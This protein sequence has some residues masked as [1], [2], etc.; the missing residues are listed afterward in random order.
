[1][2]KGADTGVE[3]RLPPPPPGKRPLDKGMMK[4]G[5]GALLFVVIT[6]TVLFAPFL[7]HEVERY[8]LG[9]IRV[10]N[11]GLSTLCEVEIIDEGVG[12][13]YSATFHVENGTGTA[14]TFIGRNEMGLL[15]ASVPGVGSF[16]CHVE[17]D[18]PTA[19]EKTSLARMLYD[20]LMGA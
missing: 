16:F 9:T 12:G 17:V 19:K 10:T 18:A 1:M 8:K 2:N 14:S 3:S 13:E 20:G 11:Y 4:R 6:L 15:N 7:D 5:I